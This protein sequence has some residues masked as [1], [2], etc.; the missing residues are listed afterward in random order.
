MEGVVSRRDCR[1]MDTVVICPTC[2]PEK[3]KSVTEGEG[4]H[5]SLM[6]SHI[7]HHTRHTRHTSGSAVT[8]QGAAYRQQGRGHCWAEPALSLRFF[9]EDCH[10]LITS[11]WKR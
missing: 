5:V 8:S 10:M 1:L 2:Q 7:T 3:A 4:C 6:V 11:N 9:T